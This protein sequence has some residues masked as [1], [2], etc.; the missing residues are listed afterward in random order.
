M[1]YGLNLDTIKDTASGIYHDIRHANY[2]QRSTATF[3]C[4]RA[5]DGSCWGFPIST[6]AQLLVTTSLSGTLEYCFDRQT[7]N[8][9][10]NIA[11]SNRPEDH[12]GCAD[13]TTGHA[14]EVDS[15]QG[16]HE[17][18]ALTTSNDGADLEQESSEPEVHYEHVDL[19]NEEASKQGCVSK[20]RACQV[21]KGQMKAA[22][23]GSLAGAAGVGL[24]AC[25]TTAPLGAAA[26]NTAVNQLLSVK[27]QEAFELHSYDYYRNLAYLTSFIASLE[28]TYKHLDEKGMQFD[29]Q[30]PKN[31]LKLL[32]FAVAKTL[33]ANGVNGLLNTGLKQGHS[34]RPVADN[35]QHVTNQD[36]V[37]TQAEGQFQAYNT[38]VPG[39]SHNGVHACDSSP[40][41]N[42]PS[43][44]SS[45][46]TLPAWLADNRALKSILALPGFATMVSRVLADCHTPSA[47]ISG[48][49][50]A[51]FS[52]DC[53]SSPQ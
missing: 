19:P 13:A 50:L 43:G 1:P 14:K 38:A 52:A 12:K 10:T 34:Q 3:F 36:H 2:Y 32:G 42:W 28:S 18:E 26:T 33:T 7:D 31:F 8:T 49:V 9:Q 29:R 37:H 22:L 5:L 4:L 39:I 15:K 45:T 21:F 41:E 35:Q 44:H 23:C 53:Q 51:G 16:E 40:Q 47:V 20:Q 48:M 27:W 30:H 25:F 17:K 6:A 11:I 46:A 24:T